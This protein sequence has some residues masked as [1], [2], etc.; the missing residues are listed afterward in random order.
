MYTIEYFA[1]LDLHFFSNNVLLNY[2]YFI[3]EINIHAIPHL[4]AITNIT[5]VL[6]SITFLIQP[7][8]LSVYF[9]LFEKQ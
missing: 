9:V 7:I 1:I 6:L 2:M 5:E 3:Y 8:H 4:Y